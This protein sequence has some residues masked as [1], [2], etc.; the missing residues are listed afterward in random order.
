MQL[1]HKGP[2]WCFLIRPSSGAF[3]LLREKENPFTV[4]RRASLN[5]IDWL[6]MV[7]FFCCCCFFFFLYSAQDAAKWHSDSKK[8]KSFLSVGVSVARAKR[9]K[10]NALLCRVLVKVR[11]VTGKYFVLRLVGG[12]PWLML[13]VP[14]CACIWVTRFPSCPSCLL[15]VADGAC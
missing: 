12:R 11:T 9:G 5:L 6:A 2:H 4:K 8:Q 3:S 7:N 14:L 15:Y 1:L 13:F 10:K